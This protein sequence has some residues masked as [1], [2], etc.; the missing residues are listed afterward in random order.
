M[1]IDIV[2]EKHIREY[3]LDLVKDEST[4]YDLDYNKMGLNDLGSFYQKSVPT[5]LAQ[6]ILPKMTMIPSDVL[7]LLTKPE[8]VIENIQI[9]EHS[10]EK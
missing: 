10:A 8:A 5:K 3:L 9:T 6:D 2:L 1:E 4:W 7:L